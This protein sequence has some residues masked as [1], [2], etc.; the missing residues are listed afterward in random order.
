MIGFPFWQ[1]WLLSV[2]WIV[3]VFGIG[4][5]LSSGTAIFDLFNRQVDPT[6]WGAN[7]VG[8]A[9]KQF[10]HWFVLDTGLSIFYKVY[11]NVAF[12]IPLLALIMLPLVFTQKEFCQ[13]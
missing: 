3:T 13:T 7:T 1:K 12:N 4:M 9:A 11:F 2:S 6:F 8:D 5:T 10:Q